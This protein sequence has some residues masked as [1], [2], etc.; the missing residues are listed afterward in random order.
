MTSDALLERLR[1][2]IARLPDVTETVTW[3]HPTWRVGGE[4]GK[5]ICGYGEE[6]GAHRVSFKVR[7]ELRSDLLADP[8]YRVAPYVGRFGWLDYDLDAGKPDWKQISALIAMSHE[9]I[10][11]AAT[12]RTA[13]PRAAKPR[14]RA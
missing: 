3:G 9:L 14:R 4:R 11:A 1:A 12:R 10:G 2:I 13:K 8:R 5:I 7:D 6:R